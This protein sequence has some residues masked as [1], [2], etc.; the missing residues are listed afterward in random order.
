MLAFHRR[1]STRQRPRQRTQELRVF[2]LVVIQMVLLR[3]IRIATKQLVGTFAGKH[4]LHVLRRVS[5]QEIQRVFR[6]IRQRL[7]QVI[8]DVGHAVEEVIGG[9]LVRNVRRAQLFR[10]ALRIRKLAVLF[11]LVAHG[12]RADA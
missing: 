7:V 3:V 10:K 9:N 5:T 2:A 11:F 4:H 6:R 12:K 1:Q 8:L